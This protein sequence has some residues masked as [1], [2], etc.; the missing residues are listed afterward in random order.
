M[1]LRS[2]LAAAVLLMT[3]RAATATEWPTSQRRFHG[4]VRVVSSA[5]NPN[6][7]GARD[8]G[9]VVTLERMGLRRMRVLT[10]ADGG[11]KVEQIGMIRREAAAG[12]GERIEVVF[13]GIEYAASAEEAL[14]AGWR[15]VAGGRIPV[16]AAT[17]TA[18]LTIIDDRLTMQTTQT[19]ERGRVAGL[20]GVAM[21][22]VVPSRVT[23]GSYGALVE[24]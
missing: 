16:A 12:G 9:V 5:A 3:T 24:E 7:P 13:G 10:Q 2:L 4:K 23:N 20:R 21:E 6:L 1:T 11:A 17:G 15:R 22:A 8:V 14:N 19:I 18:T